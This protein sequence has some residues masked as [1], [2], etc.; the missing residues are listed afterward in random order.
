MLMYVGG[1]VLL[2][3]FPFM[4]EVR[5][6]VLTRFR[7]GDTFLLLTGQSAAYGQSTSNSTPTPPLYMDS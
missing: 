1:V 7:A 4:G 3:N 2:R 5:L 6:A